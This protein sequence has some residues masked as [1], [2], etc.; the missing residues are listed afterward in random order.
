MP[1]VFQNSI[2]TQVAGNVA[3]DSTTHRIV[4]HLLG[5]FDD[6]RRHPGDRASHAPGESAPL[7]ARSATLRAVFGRFPTGGAS[8]ASEPLCQSSRCWRAEDTASWRVLAPSLR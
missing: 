8:R 3:S 1:S 6:P 2:S 4:D 7:G 5:D